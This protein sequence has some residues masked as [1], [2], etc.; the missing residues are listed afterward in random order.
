MQEAQQSASEL[1]IVDSS[2]ANISGS[3]GFQPADSGILPP[4]FQP[5]VDAVHP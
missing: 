3:A 4:S 1:F 5:I 2:D